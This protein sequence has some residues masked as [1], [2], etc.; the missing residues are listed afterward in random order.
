MNIENL[1]ITDKESL[2]DLDKCAKHLK[3]EI[4]KSKLRIKAKEKQLEYIGNLL[5]A[6]DYEQ[7]KP[8]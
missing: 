4:T 2:E 8:S 3:S 5:K 7:G 1:K 6:Y